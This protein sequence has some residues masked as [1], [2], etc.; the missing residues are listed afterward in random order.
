MKSTGGEQT[1]LLCDCSLNQEG[2]LQMSP[3]TQVTDKH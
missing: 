1:S 2:H 3:G